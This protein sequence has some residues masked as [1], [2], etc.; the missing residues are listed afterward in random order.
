VYL[1]TGSKDMKFINYF[2]KNN[3]KTEFEIFDNPQ[4]F[5]DKLKS[6]VEERLADVEE[7]GYKGAKRCLIIFEDCQ[8]YKK[9]TKTKHFQDSFTNGRHWNCMIFFTVQYYYRCPKNMRCNCNN[10]FYFLGNKK[11]LDLILE[12][13]VPPNMNKKDFEKMIK[14]ACAEPYNFFTIYRKLLH[15]ERYR[16][17]LTTILQPY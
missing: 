12:E 6:L 8:N 17:N 16:K 9:F 11:E 14:F 4:E 2:K 1:F 13:E 15:K 3:K 10:I 7:N 5:P